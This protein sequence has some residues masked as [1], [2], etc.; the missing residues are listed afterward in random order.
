MMV[1][2]KYKFLSHHKVVTPEVSVRRF[3]IFITRLLASTNN[4]RFQ[5]LL[6]QL[7]QSR[8]TDVKDCF[9]DQGNKMFNNQLPPILLDKRKDAMSQHLA[10]F[11]Y[12]TLK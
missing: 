11:A 7:W 9:K 3:S 10:S 2:I 5:H 8:F 1:I 12:G 4:H 6:K